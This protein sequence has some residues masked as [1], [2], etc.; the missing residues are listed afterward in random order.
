MKRRNVYEIAIEQ[1]EILTSKVNKLS[2]ELENLM[3][4]KTTLEKRYD[5]LSHNFLKMK[6][7]IQ[8]L[9]YKG[10]DACQGLQCL[11]RSMWCVMCISEGLCAWKASVYLSKRINSSLLTKIFISIG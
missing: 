2:D 4:G 5:E 8:R 6:C 7:I 1:N 11:W 9:R 10:G 3:K